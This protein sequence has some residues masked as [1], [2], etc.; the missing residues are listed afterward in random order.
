MQKPGTSMSRKELVNAYKQ[1]IPT[2]GVYQIKNLT[3]SK[4]ILGSAKD[5]KGIINRY[6]FQLKNGMHPNKQLQKDFSETGEGNFT[7]EI[8]DYLTPKENIKDDYTKELR[9][10]EE[11][12]LE[13]LQP[14]DDRGYHKKKT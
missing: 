4:I 6:R 7:F 11:M 12:W 2:M 10:L 9:R 3:N 13:K 14:Y 5:L 1:S 8:L